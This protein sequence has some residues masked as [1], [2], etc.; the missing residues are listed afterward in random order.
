LPGRRAGQADRLINGLTAGRR[1]GAAS[2]ESLDGVLELLGLTVTVHASV[3]TLAC[4]AFWFTISLGHAT[5]IAYK[6]YCD[7]TL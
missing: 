1:H 3:L 7:G 5:T 6:S 4:G 2:K